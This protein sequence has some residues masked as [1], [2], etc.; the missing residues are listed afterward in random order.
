VVSIS[1]RFET[2]DVIICTYFEAVFH[3]NLFNHNVA[4]YVDLRGTGTQIL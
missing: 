1:E 3:K 4:K 2:K